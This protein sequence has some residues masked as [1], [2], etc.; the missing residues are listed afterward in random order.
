MLVSCISKALPTEIRKLFLLIASDIFGGYTIF[1]S[2]FSDVALLLK[3]EEKKSE[4]ML[5]SS[6]V[7][8]YVMSKLFRELCVCVG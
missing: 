8:G 2:V 4:R 5:P 3:E 1:S 6:A 7:M